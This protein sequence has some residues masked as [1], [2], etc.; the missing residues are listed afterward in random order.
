MTRAADHVFRTPP[1]RRHWP[2]WIWSTSA[3][4]VPAACP[5][6]ESSCDPAS[7]AHPTALRAV[8]PLSPPR[9][10]CD[11]NFEQTKSSLG[12]S[13]QVYFRPVSMPDPAFRSAPHS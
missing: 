11:L 12:L 1:D 6:A 5:V 8:V 9:G 10:V 7:A 13:G 2:A 4:A 3:L